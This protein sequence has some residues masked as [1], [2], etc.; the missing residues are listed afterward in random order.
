MFEY[1]DCKANVVSFDNNMRVNDL[2]IGSDVTAY[3][4][5]DGT[6]VLLMVHEDIDY[7]SQANRI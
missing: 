2:P 6:T 3:D 4:C 7:T 1:T 5:A